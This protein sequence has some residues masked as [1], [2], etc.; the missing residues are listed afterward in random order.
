LPWQ[1]KAKT[2]KIF[3][4]KTIGP[5]AKIFG[6][7]H[8]LVD[9]YQSC[10]NYGPRVKIGPAPGGLGFYIVLYSKT[11]KI[12]SSGTVWPRVKIFGM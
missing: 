2:L 8:D 9:L 12:F 1:P 10:S 6:I 5:R 7:W 4:S 11:L 3:F